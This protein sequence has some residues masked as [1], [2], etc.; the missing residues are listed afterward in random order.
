MLYK[1]ETQLNIPYNS[2]KFYFLYKNLNI[3]DIEYITHNKYY[4]ITK[5]ELLMIDLYVICNKINQLL[6]L[7]II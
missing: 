7:K 2:L 6:D 4:P 5:I 3:N 1:L